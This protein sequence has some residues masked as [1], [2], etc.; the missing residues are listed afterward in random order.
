MTA[1]DCTASVGRLFVTDLKTKVQ[2]LVDTGS[3]LCVYPA[4]Y[5]RG[6]RIKTDYQL[7]AANG[8]IIA[9]YGYVNLKLDFGLRRAFDWRFVIADITKPIIGVDFLS[10]YNLLVDTR[11][12]RLIDGVTLLTTTAYPVC[13]SIQHIKVVSGSTRYHQ[14]LLEYPEVTRPAGDPRKRIVK[15]TTQHFIR[16]TSG[17]P[18]H[19]RPRRLAPDRLRIAKQEFEDMLRAGTARRSDSSWSSPL[20]L[21]PKKDNNWRP[22]GDYR[23]L[24]ARTIADRY[25]VRHIGDFSH[26]LY[27][28]AKCFLK[29]IL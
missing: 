8:S 6:R 15:H 20:H 13:S 21:V 2:Y 18:V 12:H 27:T 14:I 3:D 4:K 26:N 5:F 22:C 23:A 9:T 19:C 1:S 28:V 7:F 10:F 29:L 25:P 17:P 16:T 11:Q 24:N